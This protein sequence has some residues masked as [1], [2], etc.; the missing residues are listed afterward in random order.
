ME[1]PVDAEFRDDQAG[2]S[3]KPD[4]LP[5]RRDLPLVSLSKAPCFNIPGDKSFSVLKKGS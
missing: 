3:L 4:E 2:E 1:D 5:F